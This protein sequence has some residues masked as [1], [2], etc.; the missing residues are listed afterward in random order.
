MVLSLL[1]RHPDASFTLS[2]ICQRLDLNVSTAHSLLNALTA[3]EF[4]VRQPTTKRYS[5]GPELVR[6]GAAAPLIGA[7]VMFAACYGIGNG[8]MTLARA[9]IPLVFYDKA[10]FAKATSHIALP[11]NLISAAAPPLMAALL[12]RFGS[13]AVLELALICSIGALAMLALLGRRRVVGVPV[14]S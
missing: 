12:T 11:L 2:E 13:D 1:S 9:T 6:I 8:L 10:A 5:L 3:A 7:A 14:T 4:L